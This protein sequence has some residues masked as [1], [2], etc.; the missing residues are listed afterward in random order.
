LF[1]VFFFGLAFGG[2]FGSLLGTGAFPAQGFFG[3]KLR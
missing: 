1:A 3:G 2:G